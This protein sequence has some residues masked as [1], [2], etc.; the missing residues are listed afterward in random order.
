MG[1][2]GGSRAFLGVSWD[3]LVSR[4]G[5][6]VGG[7][8]RLFVGS[9]PFH[10]KKNVC[11]PSQACAQDREGTSNRKAQIVNELIVSALWLESM[12]D[13]FGH[14]AMISRYL[15]QAGMVIL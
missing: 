14:G 13:V 3:R 9:Q 5:R 1:I 4:P 15:V 6:H 10:K 11:L 8:G 2:L 7:F 12:A